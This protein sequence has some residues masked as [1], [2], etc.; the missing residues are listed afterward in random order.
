MLLPSPTAAVLRR[1]GHHEHRGRCVAG[2]SFCGHRTGDRNAAA[3]GYVDAAVGGAV[4]V[5]GIVFVT[6]RVRRGVVVV[7]I[8][9]A[10]FV[11]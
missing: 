7:V 8:E 3:G 5:V 10:A 4:L 11:E 1:G 2:N 9:D 6:K